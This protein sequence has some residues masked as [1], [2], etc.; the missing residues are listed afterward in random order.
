[1]LK[2]KNLIA[3]VICAAFVFIFLFS[4]IFIAVEGDHDCTGEDC[5]IC[6]EIQACIQTLQTL[7]TALS[8]FIL[9]ATVIYIS[10]IRTANSYQRSALHTLVTL[11]V[12]L[13]D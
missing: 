4:V 5:P 12:K 10:V 3:G 2:N 7:G 6:M 8:S 13:T 1:M 11:K 9:L